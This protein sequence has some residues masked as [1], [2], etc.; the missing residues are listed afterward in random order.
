MSHLGIGGNS[1]TGSDRVTE[2]NPCSTDASPCNWVV[3][4]GEVSLEKEPD[5][6]RSGAKQSEEE[7]SWS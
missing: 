3:R 6:E 7:S 5:E 1:S 2:V 4:L